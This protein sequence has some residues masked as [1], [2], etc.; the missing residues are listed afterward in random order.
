[1][2]SEGSLF[3]WEDGA[4]TIPETVTDYLDKEIS[5]FGANDAMDLQSCRQIAFE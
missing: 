3:A 2:L 4:L 5:L 1:M